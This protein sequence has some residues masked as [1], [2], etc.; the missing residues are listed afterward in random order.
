MADQERKLARRSFL[1]AAAALPAMA[2]VPPAAAAQTFDATS[3]RGSVSLAALGVVPGAPD[4]QSRRFQSILDAASDTDQPLFLPPGVYNV[5]N[6]NLPKRVR[7]TGVPGASRLVYS[8]NGHFLLSEFADHL[9]I[10]GIV[11]D[12]AN[13]ALNEYA[14]AAL[15]I[16]NARQMV[17]ANCQVVGSTASGIHVERSAGRI[18]R[19]RV[20]GALGNC[21]IL[22]M[23]NSSFAITGNE[24]TECAN[25][26]IL[27]HRWDPGE[28][29]TIVSGNRVSK[30]RSELGGT[31]Q[32][33]N[34]IN[35]YR[36]HS[37][38]IANNQVSD[39]ALSAIRSNTGNN[40]QIT[41]NTCLRSGE[42]GIYSE[43][44]FNG[45]VIA[46]NVVDG[47]SS[48]ISSVNFNDGGRMTVISG[49]IVRNLHVGTSYDPAGMHG[50]LGISVEA[51]ASVTGNVIEKADRF[52]MNIGWGPYLRDVVVS[53]NVIRESPTGIRVSVV[54]GAGKA[55]IVDNIISGATNGAIVGHH[56][57][58]AVTGDLADGGWRSPANLSI[59][60]NTVS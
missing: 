11:I 36:A 52:G 50:G 60:R 12:G 30:I 59:A 9:E 20:S 15:R 56:W 31:G 55:I 41:G 35:V 6:I 17:I 4:D 24:V 27:I 54:E 49:N 3:L 46:N 32:N 16:A 13:R 43:F 48:G 28:D 51:D 21:G 40:V 8:G 14:G 7:L 10:D 42:T 39:C 25:G 5:S 53:A 1:G 44:A 58:E 19:T 57:E 2:L 33:G 38:M 34:G 29:G 23:E 26:G 18:E 37:V 47:A 45:A 22:G